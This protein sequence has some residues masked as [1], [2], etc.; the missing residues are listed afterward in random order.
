MFGCLLL[1]LSLGPVRSAGARLLAQI[2][3][4]AAPSAGSPAP[5]SVSD[6]VTADK[7]VQSIAGGKIN[8]QVPKRLDLPALSGR[9]RAAGLDPTGSYP[10]SLATED[11]DGDGFPDLAVG[12]ALGGRGY[13]VVY[14]GDAAAYAPQGEA[15]IRAIA[16][17]NRFPVPFR[18]ASFLELEEQPDFL[19]TGDFDHNGIKDLVTA[20]NGGQTIRLLSV[21]G[22]RA[23]AVAGLRPVAGP[24]TAMTAGDLERTNGYTD[25]VI[26]TAGT[27]GPA[28]SIYQGSASVMV[29]PP[30]VHPLA[31]AAQLLAT[32]RLGIGGEMDIAVLSDGEI[33]VF[34]PVDQFSSAAPVPLPFPARSFA[35]GDFIWDRDGQMELAVATEDG[36]VHLVTH[37]ELDTRPLS[38]EEVAEMRQAEAA[39][40][41][42][43]TTDSPIDEKNAV[44]REWRLSEINTRLNIGA[45]KSSAVD[46]VPILAS[47][48]AGVDLLSVDR[49][50]GT[51]NVTSPGN[52]FDQAGES[53]SLAVG[54]APTAVL[55][56]RLNV[57]SRPSVVVLNQDDFEPSLIFVAPSA[58]FNVTKAAD[59]NDGSCSAG[60]CS[61]REAVVAANASG[62]LD[63]I[64]FAASLN[65][66]PIQLT[67]GGSDNTAAAGDLDIND[68][69]TIMGNGAANTLLQGSSNASFTGNIGDKFFGINQ[70]GTHTTLSV[71]LQDLTVR[72]T[73][74]DIAVNGAFTQTGGGM[75]IFLTGTGAMPGPTTTLTNVTFDSNAVSHSYGGGINIDS[76][77]TGGTGVYRGTVQI[78]NS[79]I[80]NNKTL[81]TSL[82]DNPPAGGGLNLF[83]DKHNV[84]FS[85]CTITGN[86]TSADIRSNAGGINMRQSNGGVIT[87]N[88]TTVNNNTAG[89]DGGG[90]LTAFVQT[91]IMNGGSISN[92]TA[93]GFSDS[94]AA[95]GFFNGSNLNANTSL[96]GVTISNNVATAGSSGMGGAILDGA[97]SAMSV[98]GC[99][100]TGNSSDSGG[101][102]LTNNAGGTQTTTLTN[103]VITGNSATTGGALFVNSGILNASLNYINGN[104]ATT[105]QGIARTGG[106]AT[107][108]NNWWGCDGFPSDAGCQTGS[109]T[110]DA[111][112]RIDLRLAAAPTSVLLGGSSTLT[113][114]VIKNTDGNNTNGGNAPSVLVGR[115]LTFDAG[116][117]G[118]INAPLVVTVPVNGTVTKTFTA[119]TN[120]AAC[121]IALP[122][123]VLDNTPQTAS[124]TVLCAD[125]TVAKSNNV[126]NSS[127]VGQQWTWTLTVTN[128]GNTS[129]TFASGT[130]I[131][132]DNLPNGANIIY[133]APATAANATCTING[134]KDLTCTA[135]AGG[136]TIASAGNIT[137][138]IPATGAA[139]APQTNPRSG[140]TVTVD[141]GDVVVESN[142]ANNTATS[143][144]V[145]VNKADT[146]TAITNGA[147]LSST[148]TVVG[149]GYTVNFTVSVTAPGSATPTAPTGNVQVSDGAQTC[150]GAIGA[151]G[152]GS[153][154]LTSTTA[155]S[156]SLTAT[157]QG[158]TNF[159][160]SPASSPAVAH[161]VNK[162]STTTTI[163]NAAALGTA[164]VTGQAYA[165]TWSV[166][167]DSPGALGA[168]MTGN[169]T[170]SDGV[171]SCVAGV[172]AG[173]CNLT[174]T[175]AGS[176]TI[177]ATYAGDANY[178]AS[179]ASTG[180]P[181]QVNKASTTVTIT[182]AAALGTATVTGQSYTVQWSV[183]VDSPGSLSGSKSLAIG[184]PTGTVTATDGVSTC[185]AT[186]PTNSCSLTSTTAGVKTITATYNGDTNYNAS[187]ASTGV[188]HTVNKA[189]TTTTITNAAALTV[190]TNV[191]Q[192]Y[193]VAWS[194][195]VTSPGAGSPTGTVTASDGTDSC[196]AA[197]GLGQCALTSTTSGAKNITATYNGDND[198]NASPPSV[199][200]PH[201]V[202]AGKAPLDF[203]GDGTTDYAVVRDGGPVPPPGEIDPSTGTMDLQRTEPT[204]D[205]TGR[206]AG[207]QRGYYFKLPGERFDPTEPHLARPDTA[208]VNQM[209]WSI[210]TSGPGPDLSILFGTLN[211]FP[212]P[213]DYDGDGICDI[214]VWTG[215]VGAQFKVLTSASGFVTTVTYTL[216]DAMSDPSVVGDY[217]G[218]GR[219]DPAVVDRTN[220]QW[221]YLGGATHTV[222]TTVTPIG[223]FGGGFPAPGDYDG[224][225]KYDFMLETR[226]GVNPTMGHFYLWN[227]TGIV[228]PV[229]TANFA[230]GNYRDL[231]LPGDYDGDG[232]TDLALAS[233]IVNPVAWRIRMTNGGTLLGP[234]NLGNPAIDYTITGDYNGDQKAELT[235]FH[236][237]ATTQFDSLLAPPFT[238]H[239]TANFGQAGDYPVAY[240]NAH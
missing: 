130:T 2:A 53:R 71:T 95:G 15:A 156:K 164:T 165:V 3:D 220:G 148:P 205:P 139:P 77:G 8:F 158:D 239:Q 228:N 150:S 35:I 175:T 83:A 209:R 195:S 132:T 87:L 182:N 163:T 190:P 89:S 137:V 24:I 218:D 82:S 92:N 140:G 219:A 105:G 29:Q 224:D 25:L 17:E 212:V 107:V 125:F 110:F 136:V 34:R 117:K 37:G 51:I 199:S 227:N 128:G 236:P 171:S 193:N 176:K 217:D 126:S 94:A 135:N 153:C 143:N 213:A 167:V 119:N 96:S 189:N 210:N 5:G 237:P 19:V 64:T 229:A 118:S 129:G 22:S 216:G 73:R 196:T 192:P 222:S 184:G 101:A 50:S 48:S 151:G 56:M 55:P 169:V 230:F 149:Q 26:A 80:S 46:L 41:D 33:T 120:S 181:H 100:I 115:N 183:T 166:S 84:T 204:L 98:D 141:P 18:D 6:G 131:L 43:G 11:F 114:D 226:D 180:V 86:Q 127:V 93:Q 85:G 99:T 232:K 147:A 75:D 215:G 159:N 63:T 12:Y 68:D 54:S 186:I 133:G 42:S 225:G 157:Y 58:T 124:V 138:T 123:V 65:G 16:R 200:V 108:E 97:N 191:G 235:I 21:G 60:D 7:R 172:G 179:P 52:A 9:L 88:S 206:S 177:T 240:F 145:T 144:T 111:N 4:P 66:T 62:G 231:V 197:I 112:P 1:A 155:G 106:T 45:E 208:M 10:L 69:V 211:D 168:V 170:V 44:P 187:P 74:N 36:A 142:E 90:I 234:F 102:V 76:G 173:T 122:S 178:N 14:F 32:G 78:T 70:D 202:N 61:L 27:D 31:N 59:T 30:L 20:A 233:L 38:A 223:T 207:P 91:V 57:H 201:T 103:N 238:T 28:L 47:G 67:I 161:T 185:M 23:L 109:G 221:T 198:F 40:R 152:T 160:A 174:S 113:A 49:S 194:V 104:T 214:A 116:T 162:A 154:V 79:T 203:D 13:L 146:T 121:G 81:S 39:R 188:S 72:F 134:T